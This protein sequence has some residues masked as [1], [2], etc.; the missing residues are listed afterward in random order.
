MP[1]ELIEQ[2]RASFERN[3][4]RTNA[5]AMCA[6]M[7]DLYTYFGIKSELRKELAKPIIN[8]IRN[9]KSVN[10]DFVFQCFEQEEREFQYVAL[11]YLRKSH[12]KLLPEHL[13]E[14]KSL[15]LSKSWWDTV[16][17][18]ATE[19]GVLVKKDPT[20]KEVMKTWANHDNMWIR[21]VSMIH[22][23]K[24]KDKVD[25]A[26]LSYCIESNLGSKEFF[27]NKAIGWSLRSYSQVNPHWV[28]DF[29]NTHELAPL[30]RKEAL[31]KIKVG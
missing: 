2:L 19:V 29:A 10:W 8:E 3:A 30:S 22:Q 4:N 14:L 20:I 12:R 9:E 11:D 26:L 25:T 17:A 28:I 23:L 18:I 5:V 21:R 7:K 1:M 16:D 6:Y 24:F 13:S 15:I 31:R 27:I